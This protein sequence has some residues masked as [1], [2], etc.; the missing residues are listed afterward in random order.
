M[1]PTAETTTPAQAAARALGLA[2]VICRGHMESA[3]GDQKAKEM[4][5]LVAKW[6]ADSGAG[7]E[8]AAEERALVL[9]PLGSLDRT[10]RAAAL[11]RVEQLGVLAWAL[12]RAPLGAPDESPHDRWLARR[13]GFLGADA[14]QRIAAA[15]LRP[16]DEVHRYALRALAIAARLEQFALDRKRADFEGLCTARG[17]SGV[18]FLDRDLAVG[19]TTLAAVPTRRWQALLV[20]AVERARAAHWLIAPRLVAARHPVDA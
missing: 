16:E 4:Q 15:E 7:V 19:G 8:L 14:A 1:L 3:A 2:A 17:I 11:W 13:V 18:A 5:V 10:T 12:G 6:L 20:A 9:A